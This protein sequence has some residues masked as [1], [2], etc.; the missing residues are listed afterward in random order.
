MQKHLS[1]DTTPI[2]RPYTSPTLIHYGNLRTLTKGGTGLLQENDQTP[3]QAQP[4]R[5]P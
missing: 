1:E 3:P 4:H 5:Y 2:K